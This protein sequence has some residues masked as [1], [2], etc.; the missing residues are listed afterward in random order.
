M[1]NDLVVTSR[2]TVKVDGEDAAELTQDTAA[3]T[4]APVI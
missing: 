4:R 3:L 2:P 1:A